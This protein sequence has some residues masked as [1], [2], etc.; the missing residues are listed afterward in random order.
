MNVIELAKKWREEKGYTGKGGVIVIHEGEVNSWVNELRD[1]EHWAPGCIAVDEAGN[2]W[3]SVGG[4]DK[5]GSKTWEPVAESAAVGFTAAELEKM[6]DNFV[7][8]W[9]D[10]LGK[11]DH[12]AAAANLLQKK[13]LPIAQQLLALLKAGK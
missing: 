5:K 1:P 12:D 7:D 13:A 9:S 4:N 8:Y 2:M 11:G 3:V 10:P 6:I